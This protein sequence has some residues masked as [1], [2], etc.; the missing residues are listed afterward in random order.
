MQIFILCFAAFCSH[1][2]SKVDFVKFIEHIFQEKKIKL[3]DIPITQAI[4]N[5]ACMFNDKDD[6]AKINYIFSTIQMTQI[7]FAAAEI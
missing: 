1:L 7:S 4:I 3:N 6:R 5:F 2:L